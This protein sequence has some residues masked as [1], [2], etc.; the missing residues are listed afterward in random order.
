MIGGKLLQGEEGDL[1]LITMK[2]TVP[3]IQLVIAQTQPHHNSNLLIKR[4]NLPEGPIRRAQHQDPGVATI[5]YKQGIQGWGV[6]HT[7][8]VALHTLYLPLHLPHHL[9]TLT[10]HSSD[11]QVHRYPGH[12]GVMIEVSFFCDCFM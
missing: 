1:L 3:H 2:A 8:W 9:L 7:M 6:D 4:Q 11:K 10:G 12:L 5:S